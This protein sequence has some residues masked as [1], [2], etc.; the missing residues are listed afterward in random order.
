VDLTSAWKDQENARQGVVTTRK[1]IATNQEAYASAEALYRHGKAIG[2]DVLQAQVDLTSSRFTY[3]KYAV[4]YEIGQARIKQIMGAGQTL[5]S[6]P[7]N[8]GGPKP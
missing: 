3:I 7:G 1:T 6:Q 8:R 2:L 4:A 5:S